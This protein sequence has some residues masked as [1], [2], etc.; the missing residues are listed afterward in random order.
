M[1]QILQVKNGFTF[2]DRTG[3]VQSAITSILQEYLMV[4]NVSSVRL[5]LDQVNVWPFIIVQKN[6][7]K[8]VM[9][10][11]QKYTTTYNFTLWWYFAGNDPKVLEQVQHEM[12]EAIEKLFS[13]NALGDLNTSTP[14]KQFMQY[15]SL[16]YD[17]MLSSVDYS[18]LMQT[19]A[20]KNMNYVM[21]G[22]VNITLFA[23]Y[24]NN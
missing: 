5:P 18:P 12:G 20:I 19:Q 3:Q 14:T 21:A 13:N 7:K 10:T 17:T 8:P 9:K 11:T 22:K 6:S 16:W 4:Q 2:T 24:L 15:G 1:P 23:Y